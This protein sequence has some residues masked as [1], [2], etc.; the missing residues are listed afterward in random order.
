MVI[1]HSIYRR[2][3]VEEIVAVLRLIRALCPLKQ[4][5]EPGFSA[6]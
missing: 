3:G 6:R 1:Y 4:N 5:S 2:I